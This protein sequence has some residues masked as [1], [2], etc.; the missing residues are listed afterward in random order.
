MFV[1][2]KQKNEVYSLP[3]KEISHR[4]AN[5]FSSELAIKILKLLAKEP[6][7]PIELAK[8]LKEL[9]QLKEIVFKKEE[10]QPQ[11]STPSQ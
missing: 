5:I 3:V 6:M 11:K 7:Y 8:K 1:V 10:K 2:K 9:T 4:D